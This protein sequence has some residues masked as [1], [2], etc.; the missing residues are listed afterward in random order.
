MEK[1]DRYREFRLC[2]GVR[3]N[4]R[5]QQVQLS[6]VFVEPFGETRNAFI[7]RS[8]EC[9]FMLELEIVEGGGGQQEGAAGPRGGDV[10]LHHLP[11]HCLQACDHTL[12]S[13]LLP[14]LY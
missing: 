5:S 6:Q 13:Q 3:K 11:G 8:R 7:V 12:P 2:C 10:L 1:L 14:L 4:R 9:R